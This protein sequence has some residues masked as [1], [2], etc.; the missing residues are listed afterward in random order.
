MWLMCLVRLH[1]LAKMK[2]NC[3][4]PRNTCVFVFSNGVAD[5]HDFFD[6]VELP[7]RLGAVV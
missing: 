7:E 1:C 2:G 5:L 6:L 4:L 3:Y